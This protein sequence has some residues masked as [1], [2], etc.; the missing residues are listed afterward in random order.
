M[1]SNVKQLPYKPFNDLLMSRSWRYMLPFYNFTISLLLYKEASKA[2]L[3]GLS[4]LPTYNP[5]CAHK[6]ALTYFANSSYH[7]RTYKKRKAEVKAP[8][9]DDSERSMGA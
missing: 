1:H 7:K 5:Q 2:Y 3:V 4:V 9:I 8:V 6:I